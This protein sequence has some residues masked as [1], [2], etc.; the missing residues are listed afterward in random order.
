MKY[1]LN[2]SANNPYNVNLK[3]KMK[4]NGKYVVGDE[5]TWKDGEDLTQKDRF[6]SIHSNDIY[7]IEWK[8]ID[9]PNDTEVGETDG[10]VYTLKVQAYAEQQ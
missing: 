2:F 4:L 3:F 6:I 1:D 9:A 5:S 7:T 10:A 8:W